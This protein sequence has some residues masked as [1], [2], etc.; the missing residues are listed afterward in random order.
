MIKPETNEVALQDQFECVETY[1]SFIAQCEYQISGFGTD[2][3]GDE[4]VDVWYVKC[5]NDENQEEFTILK[6]TINA[7]FKIKTLK[8]I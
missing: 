6:P 8:H 7:L 2:W 1:K 3:R 5:L 4:K